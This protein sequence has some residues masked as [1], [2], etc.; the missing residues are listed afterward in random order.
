M[1]KD[2]VQQ[3]CRAGAEYDTREAAERCAKERMTATKSPH[4]VE[5]H[6]IF[7]GRGGRDARDADNLL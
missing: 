4:F 2:S 3:V 6:R 7:Y 1:G 5:A